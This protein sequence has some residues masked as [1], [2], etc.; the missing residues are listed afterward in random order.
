MIRSLLLFIWL[1]LF[2]L[3]LSIQSGREESS[4]YSILHLRESKPFKCTSVQNDFDEIVRIE[5]QMS[6][7]HPLPPIINPYF[8][9]QHTP[10]SLI[11]T[12]KKKI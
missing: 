3:D 4:G 11:I 9:L 7:S 10:S 12:P 6:N 1:P 8:S 2:A 5:C